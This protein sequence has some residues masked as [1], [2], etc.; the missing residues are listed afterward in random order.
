[1]AIR[2]HYQN[3]KFQISGS[4]QIKK[5]LISAA[6]NEG[7][8]IADLSY[9]FIDD[10]SQRHINSEFLEHDYNTDVITFDYSS[11]KTIRGEIYIAIETVKRNSV[12]YKTKFRQ[13]YLRVMIHG[14]LHLAGYNDKGEDESKEM[15]VK[16][17]YYLSRINNG[18]Y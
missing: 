3:V 1:V 13:E 8:R 12:N 14:L 15:R 5:W 11:G 9:F 6:V 7:Y 16:E 4:A 2:V 17:D 10:D 18:K